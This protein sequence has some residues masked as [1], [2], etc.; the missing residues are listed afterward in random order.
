MPKNIFIQSLNWAMAVNEQRA[1]MEKQNRERA[2]AQTKGGELVPLDY[3]FLD[4]EDF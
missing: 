3:S 1:Q 2:K 4:E